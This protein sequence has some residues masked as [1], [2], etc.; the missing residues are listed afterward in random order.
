MKKALCVLFFLFVPFL[1][2]ADG[3]PT[4][5]QTFERWTFYNQVEDGKTMCFIASEP[6][7]IAGHQTDHG[8]SY[9]WV[10]HIT[11]NI[12]EV[13]ITSGYEY[14]NS[15]LPQLATYRKRDEFLKHKQA[16][17][18]S[19]RT[20]NC[21]KG[22]PSDIYIFDLIEGERAWFRKVEND[23]NAVRSMNGD[24]YAVVIAKSS[25]NGCSLN[26][27]SLRGFAKAYSEMKKNCS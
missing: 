23:E 3:T 9:L 4:K 18:N 27:Y 7:F 20:G 19:A 15:P 10:K 24:L 25:Q 6:F 5:I 22:K 13:S 11:A 21:N 8:A 16:M 2:L 12:D 26:F 17:I 1:T 14:G